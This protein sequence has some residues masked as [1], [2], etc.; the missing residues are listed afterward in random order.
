MEVIS[1]CAADRSGCFDQ[2]LFSLH[3]LLLMHVDGAVTDDTAINST[4]ILEV[5]Q[6]SE[7]CGSG[8]ATSGSISIYLY[9]M[10]SAG[11]LLTILTLLNNS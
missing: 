10:L 8:R 7:I 4:L 5:P 6:A 3:R 1:V 9:W 11:T 2:T